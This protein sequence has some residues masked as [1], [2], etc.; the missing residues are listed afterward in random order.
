MSG[1]LS[2]PAS[3]GGSKED[4]PLAMR[5]ARPKKCLWALPSHATEPQGIDG[6]FVPSDVMPQDRHIWISTTP[7][8]VLDA[9]DAANKGLMGYECAY[10]CLLKLSRSPLGP[11]HTCTSLWRKQFI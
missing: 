9:T 6:P 1:L 10:H 3:P 2:Q 8:W 4:H 5:E 7:A 11:P